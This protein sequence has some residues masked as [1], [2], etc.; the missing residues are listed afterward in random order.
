MARAGWAWRRRRTGRSRR[1]A[2]RPPPTRRPCA[3]AGVACSS[4]PS[5]RILGVRAQRLQQQR[6]PLA[7]ALRRTRRPRT[8]ARSRACA[9][10]HPPAPEIDRRLRLEGQRPERIRPAPRSRCEP[11]LCSASASPVAHLPLHREQRRLDPATP[12]RPAASAA[13]ASSRRI[14]RRHRPRGRSAAAPSA[15]APA[16]ECPG[17]AGTL[18][19]PE[20]RD[21]RV[22]RARQLRRV[23]AEPV[24][25]ARSSA[26]RVARRYA[27]DSRA[28]AWRVPPRD[29]NC[30]APTPTSTTQRPRAPPAIRNDER[31][32]PDLLGPEPPRQSLETGRSRAFRHPGKRVADHNGA[33]PRGQT[34]R[35]LPKPPFTMW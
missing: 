2:P 7:R 5:P 15:A 1:A 26:C 31:A 6:R 9:S 21:R 20:R 33:D 22:A 14:A 35:R 23:A 24:R 27:A 8:Q 25:V 3:E 32:S 12:A 11:A 13:T 18:E 34:H 30:H 19:R 16:C 17:S 10:V 4:C 29:A 28:S